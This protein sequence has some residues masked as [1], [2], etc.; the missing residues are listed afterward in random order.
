MTEFT[1]IESEEACQA[2]NQLLRQQIWQ[3]ELL[4]PDFACVPAYE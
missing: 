2:V 4:N 1:G 3:V